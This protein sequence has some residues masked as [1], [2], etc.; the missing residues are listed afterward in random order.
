MNQEEE[1]FLVNPYGL[2]CNEVTA[3]SLI[4]V[5][6]QGNIM[7]PGTTNFGVNLSAFKLHAAIYAARP[8]LKAVIDVQV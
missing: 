4:K 6:M 1:H 2:L 5:D 8:D 7:E 3:S